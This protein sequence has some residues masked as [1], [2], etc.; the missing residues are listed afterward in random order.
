MEKIYIENNQQQQRQQNRKKG[1]N[2]TTA[3]AIV[4]GLLALASVVAAGLSFRGV[5]Y[6]IDDVITLPDSFTG[7]NGTKFYMVVD[8]EIKTQPPIVMHY[9]DF[10]GKSISVF[11]LEQ[12]NP[13]GNSQTYTKGNEITDMGLLY[14]LANLYPNKNLTASSEL[15]DAGN[16]NANHEMESWVSQ[17]AIWY[18]LS[19]NPVSGDR[20]NTLSAEK[21]SDIENACAITTS[22]SVISASNTMGFD[23]STNTI[24]ETYKVGDKTIKQLIATALTKKGQTATTFTVNGGNAL[25]KEEGDYFFSTEVTVTGSVADS[26]L[27]SFNGYKVTIDSSAPNGTVIV[28]STGKAFTSAQ[29]NNMTVNKFYIRV[30]KASIPEG[31]TKN[32]KIN[33][34]GNFTTYTGNY[35]V[36]S[37]K[38]QEVTNVSLKTT[39]KDASTQFPV[40][41]VPDTGISISQSVYLAGLLVLICG[42]GIIYINARG[43]A[44]E[45]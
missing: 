17:A 37:S 1:V 30:P 43:K 21:L 2:T 24:F 40:T 38:A 20:Y 22:D 15:L 7:R 45:Q 34:T 9:A 13:F 31:S 11:C 18:Y 36:T 4:L 39:S 44:Q 41:R 5:S 16:L 19:K 25:G 42:V 27:G 29:M 23:C 8:G 26:S 14:L 33:A 6:A 35:Y 10:S 12:S 28:D 32:I 3:L